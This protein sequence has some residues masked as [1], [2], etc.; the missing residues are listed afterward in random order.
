VTKGCDVASY[1]GTIDFDL[2]STEV[3]FVICKASEGTGYRDPSFNRNWTE[4]KRVGL[5]RGAYHFARPDLGTN[6]QDEAA[7]FL[8]S[9]GPVNPG[10]LL[11]L[12]YEVQW[13]GDVVGWCLSFLNLVRQMTGLTPL[14]YL[15]RSLV[16]GHD[17]APVINAG[18]PLWLADYDG[19]PDTVPQTPWPIVAIKQWTSSGTLPGVPAR[20]D[21]NTAFEEEDMGLREEF[22]A[23]KKTTDATIESMKRT[24]NPLYH[25]FHFSGDAVPKRTTDPLVPPVEGAEYSGSSADL[26]QVMWRFPDGTMH[27]YVDGKEAHA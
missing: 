15:N 17:W 5:T 9:I 8:S 7:Y 23:Y 10:E 27:T 2:L 6:A 24:Y 3:A 4:A 20:V 14:I 19:Q 22:E 21:L 18:Y 1:Q 11:A 26:S 13:D 25:H 16:N 12:D